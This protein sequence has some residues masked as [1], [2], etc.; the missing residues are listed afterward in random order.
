MYACSDEWRPASSTG[1]LKQPPMRCLQKPIRRGVRIQGVT[2]N[3]TRR[4]QEEE[5]EWF[6]L[7]GDTSGRLTRVS[8]S[9]T[10]TPPDPV[11]YNVYSNYI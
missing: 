3:V 8:A 6:E 11:C 4:R 1:L 2:K 5:A 7:A 10:T 9:V